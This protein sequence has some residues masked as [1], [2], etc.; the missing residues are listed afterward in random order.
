MTEPQPQRLMEAG[1]TDFERNLL[2]AGRKDQMPDGSRRAV[3]GALG[4]GTGLLP[5]AA[6]V[7][8]L[9]S[10]IAKPALAASKGGVAG[11]GAASS[12]HASAV[13][14]AT[15]AALGKGAAGASGAGAGLAGAG[16]AGGG[17]LAGGVVAKGLALSGIA[18]LVGFGAF[19]V[20]RGSGQPVDTA[21][22]P[23]TAAQVAPVVELPPK[24]D[25]TPGPAVEP[26]AVQNPNLEPAATPSS[27]RSSGR[28]RSSGAADSLGGE[29]T[30]I[31]AAR[32][33]LR[34]GDAN[35]CMRLLD[36]YSRDFPKG[37]L[38]TEATVLRIEAL[39]A[40]GE[41]DAARSLGR[42]FLA[43]SPNG[44]YARRVRSLVGE[45]VPSEPQH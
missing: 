16:L 35:R 21:P 40:L 25:A 29:L 34:A 28:V 38:R 39:S 33:A 44:P 45:N 19:G 31:D 43:R 32:G 15:T 20:M 22:T 2:R 1:A 24:R 23:V 9:E 11:Q 26:N 13:T 7:G 14:K 12:G 8:S 37:G 42:S 10:P 30:R 18:A 41:R 4:I 17:G 27:A 5:S 6:S 36:E 3:L